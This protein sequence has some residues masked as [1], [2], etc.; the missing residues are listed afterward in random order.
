MKIS[1][2]VPVIFGLQAIIKKQEIS[3]AK[4]IVRRAK[5]RGE[6]KILQIRII[7]YMDHEP[8]TLISQLWTVR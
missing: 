1:P 2:V 5:M 4:R 6:L 7:F 3:E 8:M